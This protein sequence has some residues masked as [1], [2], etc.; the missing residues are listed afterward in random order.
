MP[1]REKRHT[2]HPSDRPSGHAEKRASRK[3]AEQLHSQALHDEALEETF[4]ASDPVAPFIAAKPRSH[5]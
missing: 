3:E 1:N 4:P 5:H 2:V